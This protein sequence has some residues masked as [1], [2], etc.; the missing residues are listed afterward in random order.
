[1]TAVTDGVMVLPSF[2][3]FLSLGV[4]KGV[5]RSLRRRRRSENPDSLSEIP[6]PRVQLVT[7]KHR[8]VMNITDSL[9]RKFKDWP[10][11]LIGGDW[12]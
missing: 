11:E 3:D 8:Q 5:R 1:L 12:Y 9:D 6:A 4:A 2:H 7:R 10:P